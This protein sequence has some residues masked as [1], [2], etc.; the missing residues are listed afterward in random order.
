VWAAVLAIAAPLGYD[1]QGVALDAD[2]ILPGA[3]AEACERLK[4]A[5]E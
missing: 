5:G 4:A 3:V 2:G 1:V